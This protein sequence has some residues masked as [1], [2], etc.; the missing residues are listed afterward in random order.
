MDADGDGRVPARAWPGSVA[1]KCIRCRRDGHGS[2]LPWIGLGWLGLSC[3]GVGQGFQSSSGL[4][5][6]QITNF[7]FFISKSLIRAV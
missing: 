2:V 5:W 3:V 4:G 1:D 7:I 6:V